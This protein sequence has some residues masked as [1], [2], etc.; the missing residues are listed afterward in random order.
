[1]VLY[2]VQS[3]DG[4]FFDRL[5][6]PAVWLKHEDAL[7][8]IERMKPRKRKREG[9]RVVTFSLTPAD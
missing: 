3:A 5:G 7:A 1:M 9:W 2:A 6:L 8:I 4:S